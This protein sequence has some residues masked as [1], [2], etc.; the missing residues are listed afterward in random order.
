LVGEALG[1]TE[2]TVQR[3]VK[4]YAARVAAERASQTQ[5]SDEAADAR[6]SSAPE[7]RARLTEPVG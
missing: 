6:R 1:W 3:E 5:P 2:E 7:A 4:V